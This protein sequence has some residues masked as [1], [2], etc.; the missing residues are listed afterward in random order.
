[1]LIRPSEMEKYDRY[2]NEKENENNRGDDDV[3]S[4]PDVGV[5]HG[6]AGRGMRKDQL[7]PVKEKDRER[8]RE[9]T[10]SPHL[11]EEQKKKGGDCRRSK[12]WLETRC[13][14]GGGY[15]RCRRRRRG[16]RSERSSCGTSADGA[17]KNREGS[18]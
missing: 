15:R 6:D 1:M 16:R 18:A 13:G 4:N 17:V 14:C 9:G 10:H 3:Q 2:V 8:Q 11:Q 7:N 12:I 5:A